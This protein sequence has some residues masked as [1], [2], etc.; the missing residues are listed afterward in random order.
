M[1]NETN[2][3]TPKMNLSA[4]LKKN[5]ANEHPARLAQ[6]ETNFT[7]AQSHNALRTTHHEPRPAL[8]RTQPKTGS[9]LGLSPSQ[10]AHKTTVSPFASDG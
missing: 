4:V 3:P 8:H 9:I 2:F 10:F 1:Q 6:N 7:Q 5:Y